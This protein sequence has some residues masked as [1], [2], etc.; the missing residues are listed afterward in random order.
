[1]KLLKVKPKIR[2]LPRREGRMSAFVRPNKKFWKLCH[3]FIVHGDSL[4]ELIDKAIEQAPIHFARESLD[5]VADFK[6]NWG[7]WFKMPRKRLLGL[8]EE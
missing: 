1:M 5:D 6:S 4:P 7:D 3:E 2:I 8:T